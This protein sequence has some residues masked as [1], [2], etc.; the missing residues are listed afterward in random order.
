VTDRP[1]GVDGNRSPRIPEKI[2]LTRP[3]CRGR[4]GI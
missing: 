1:R 3:A 4:A 2:K